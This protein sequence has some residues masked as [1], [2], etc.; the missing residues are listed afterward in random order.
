MT[1]RTPLPTGIWLT[2]GVLTF[3]VL[4]VVLL[5]S[6]VPLVLVTGAVVLSAVACSVPH[7]RLLSLLGCAA[8][9]LLAL[10]PLH[11]VSSALRFAELGF[12]LVVFGVA[13]TRRRQGAR[14]APLVL[15][16]AYLAV[17]AYST[18]EAGLPDAGFQMLVL[19][20]VGM[21]FAAVGVAATDSDRRSLVRTVIAMGVAQSI[22]AVGELITQ[23]AVLWASPVPSTFQGSHVRLAHEIIDGARRSQGTF[24][25]PLLLAFFLLVA[26]GLAMRAEFKNAVTRRLVVGALVLGVAATG[27]RSALA[28]QLALLLFVGLA[29]RASGGRLIGGAIGLAVLLPLS[30]VLGSSVV[31]RFTE[32]GSVTHRQGSL[33]AVPRI[34]AQPP[35]EL[36]FGHGWYSLDRVYDQGLLIAEYGGFKAID[37]Q[38]IAFMLTTGLVGLAIWLALSA[39]LLKRAGYEY[40]LATIGALAMFFTFDVTEFPA[41]WAL[42][43]LLIGFATRPAPP[44]PER[45]ADVRSQRAAGRPRPRELRPAGRGRG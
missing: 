35:F 22:Y 2:A 27:S 8:L 20:I 43:A 31:T 32:S 33:D 29:R 18:F 44:R 39:M 38:W 6:L 1:S 13:L 36:L 37:N 11:L 42:L 34:L 40:R 16:T 3:S 45:R 4:G 24:G 15:L 23:P 9:A 30:G 19:A 7:Q 5:Q 25:H 28:I 12:L 10:A 14:S 17:T 21:T 41:D 26:T